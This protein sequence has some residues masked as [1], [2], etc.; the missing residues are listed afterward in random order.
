MKHP[1]SDRATTDTNKSQNPERAFICKLVAFGIFSSPQGRSQTHQRPDLI[2]MDDLRELQEQGVLRNKAKQNEEICKMQV[3]QLHIN[4]YGNMGQ[5]I[6]CRV[7]KHMKNM[8]IG[9]LKIG[10]SHD[11]LDAS[12]KYLGHKHLPS[13]RGLFPRW[14][15]NT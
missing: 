2:L 11:L 4:K 8:R 1:F 7:S 13:Y 9:T 10:K 5:L 12:L 15:L 3:S 14:K 6:H